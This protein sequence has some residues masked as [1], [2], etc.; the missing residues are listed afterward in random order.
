MPGRPDPVYRPPSTYV[1]DQPGGQRS[2]T[3]LYE[4]RLNDRLCNYLTPDF[5][6]PFVNPPDRR[7]I[8]VTWVNSRRETRM[9][10]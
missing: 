9:M 5:A 2:G 7:V 6:D 10:K 4:F 3:D 8:H 1:R